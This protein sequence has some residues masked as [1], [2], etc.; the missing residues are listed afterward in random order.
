[1][2]IPN[3]KSMER[4]TAMT[5]SSIHKKE[6][7]N[8]G[9]YSVTGSVLKSKKHHPA[10]HIVSSAKPISRKSISNNFNEVIPS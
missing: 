6:K 7:V 3:T 9:S 5:N 2:R 4:S 1:V 10:D 8:G